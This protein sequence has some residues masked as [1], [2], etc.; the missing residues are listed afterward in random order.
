MNDKTN[1]DAEIA[2]LVAGEAPLRVRPLTI[3]RAVWRPQSPAIFDDAVVPPT[4]PAEGLPQ[5]FVGESSMPRA[6]Q[7]RVDE[8]SDETLADDDAGDIGP[9]GDDDSNVSP[10]T[11]A[12][13]AALDH[14]D[15]DNGQRLISYFKS[16]LLVLEQHGIAGGDFLVWAGTHWD[17]GNGAARAM[18]LAQRI[19]ALIG[20]EAEFLRHTPQEEAAIAAGQRAVAEL[21]ELSAKEEQTDGDAARESELKELVGAAKKARD[22]LGSR[23][24]QRRKFAVSS[25]NKN[26]L[27]SMQDCAA[28]H[29]RRS[30]DIFNADPLKVATL[31]HTLTFVR[32]VDLECPDPDI[33]RWRWRCEA[34]RGHD[35]ADLITAL[36]PVAF[37][38]DAKPDKWAKFLDR[39]MP[40]PAQDDK[41][42]TLQ[43]YCGLGLLGVI[44]QFVM[45]HYGE[46]SNG[47][48]VFLETLMRLLGESFAVSLPPETFTG[49]GERNAGQASPDL[50]RLFGR[51]MLR[52]PEIKPGATLQE[53]LI[54]RVTGGEKLTARTLFKGYVD[55]QNK[56]KPHMSGNG[57]PKI[58]GTD[59][60]IWRRMLVMH[61]TETIAQS[62][63]KEFEHVV[64]D[65]LTEAPAILNWMIAGALDYLN[66]GFYIAPEVRKSTSDYRDDM[67]V[68]GQFRRACVAPAPGEQVQARAMYVAFKQWCTANAKTAVFETR[69]GREMK[70]HLK[71]DDSGRVNVYLDVRLERVPETPSREEPPHPAAAG[72]EEVPI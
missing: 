5:N 69:F 9:S 3:D 31:T 50:M 60:G 36:I 68:V 34:I 28:P 71:H 15:T 54:K 63:Q 45:Y 22:A 35:R 12:A 70:K 1:T 8:L 6:P 32:E 59:N 14:S 48:S 41:R 33:T 20:R 37:D 46:G 4:H 47:K 61:W 19:G 13:C 7:P 62:E 51:R 27:I 57:F 26:R 53:D 56:A 25:K 24:A 21:S 66:A 18:K 67:D 49:S 30:P 55:F 38:A 43:Q 72:D 2:A 23:R 29:L 40:S 10:D 11:I 58:D 17:I 65:L 39:F 64:T 52:V 42:R 16:D 44:V